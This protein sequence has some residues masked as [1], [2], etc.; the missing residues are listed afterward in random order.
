MVRPEWA[1]TQRQ[2]YNAPDRSNAGTPTT[3]TKRTPRGRATKARTRFVG[4]RVN[5]EST[6]RWPARAK[7]KIVPMIAPA[8]PP[9]ITGNTARYSECRLTNIANRRPA[10]S[11]VSPRMR[12][13]RVERRVR[14]ARYCDQAWRPA[15]ARPRAWRAKKGI[16][17]K[18][19]HHA[20]DVSCDG[21][22]QRAH[23]Q[24]APVGRFGQGV[25]ARKRSRPDQRKT[26]TR[27]R[28]L[29]RQPEI[30]HDLH[31]GEGI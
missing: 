26:R 22:L 29:Q 6:S 3:R 21:Q 12:D 1:S 13:V 7:P 23:H 24:P 19:P 4:L 11:G 20:A 8:L 30:R 31:C 17:G 2:K 5:P 27:P 25:F 14:H 9:A 16:V 28:S 15:I 18:C 10:A